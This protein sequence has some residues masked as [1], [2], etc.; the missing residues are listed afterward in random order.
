MLNHLQSKYEHVGC[1]TSSEVKLCP[2]PVSSASVVPDFVVSPVPDPV[3]QGP[4]GHDLLGI[5]YFLAKTL[6]GSHLLFI[7]N[8]LPLIFNSV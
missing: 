1:F 6:N 8:K 4:V 7:N 3:G 2:S 5:A